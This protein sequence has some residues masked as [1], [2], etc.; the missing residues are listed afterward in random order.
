MSD[1]RGARDEHVC[2]QDRALCKND[3][4]ADERGCEVDGRANWHIL[5]LVCVWVQ[6]C[7]LAGAFVFGA[8]EMIGRPMLWFGW[9]AVVAAAFQTAP[10]SRLVYSPQAVEIRGDDLVM[11]R[12]FPMDAIGLPRPWLSYVEIIR[13][14][15]MGYNGGHVCAQKGG[16]LQYTNAD[17]VGAWSIAWASRCTDDPVGFTWSAQ[18]SWHIGRV[19]L[20]PVKL[21][22]TALKR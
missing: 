11:Y 6:L 13:P 15:T 19:V 2:H 8:N 18:W 1:A 5:G 14:M 3:A 17:D 9:I 20:G 12:S 10:L 21:S 4:L 22:H 7:R 16:P